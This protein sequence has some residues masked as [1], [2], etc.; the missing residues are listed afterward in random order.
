MKLQACLKDIQS[1]MTSNFFLLNSDKTEHI[2]FDPK[3]LRDRLD[4]IITLDGVSVAA[5]FSV[6]NRGVTFDLDLSFNSYIQRKWSVKHY[7]RGK[8]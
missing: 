3:S 4:H 7:K 2:V 5:S 8:Y 1:W 6:T